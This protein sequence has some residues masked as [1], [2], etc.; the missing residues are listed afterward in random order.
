MSNNKK[1][2]WLK[3]KDNFFNQKEIKKL[4]R[5]A[6]G[7]TYTI[8]YLKLQLLSIKK[9]GVIEFEGTEE[10]LA[11]QL[12]LEIDEDKD[13][14]EITLRFLQAN[15]L[16]EEMFED[17]YLLTKVPECIGKECDSA[18]RV[19]KHREKLKQSNLLQSN[20]NTL[21]CNALVT[22]S[23]TEIEIEKEKEKEIEKDIDIEKK[24]KKDKK[25]IYM[26]LTFI[27][28]YIDTVKITQDQYDKLVKD[29]G[30]NIVNNTIRN[31]D[32]YIV[33]NKRK[34]KDHNRVLRTWLSKNNKQNSKGIEK[35]S[36]SS[37]LNAN[38]TYNY[39]INSLIEK[40]KSEV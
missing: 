29:Y 28:D 15:H 8:I 38:S 3:L 5:I 19:R 34:Y 27:E 36:N 39:D 21:Q 24:K 23:N 37:S 14:I 7:D 30:V 40:M 22:N 16:I 33:N 12:A 31:L 13:N 18:E 17:S 10:N 9:E 1:Y 6:G 2:F 4:R 26:D 35:K 11:E 25:L 20:T 32:N